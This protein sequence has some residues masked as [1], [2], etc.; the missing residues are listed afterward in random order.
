M[1]VC[2][3]LSVLEYLYTGLFEDLSSVI[4][5]RLRRW[6]TLSAAPFEIPAEPLLSLNNGNKVK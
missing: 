1:C 3:C 5:Q 6:L 2:V 4:G